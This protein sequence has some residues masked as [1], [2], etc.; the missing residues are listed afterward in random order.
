MHT[1]VFAIIAQ[2]AKVDFSRFFV[3]TVG[4]AVGTIVFFVGAVGTA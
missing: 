4:T 1:F 3:G 2:I